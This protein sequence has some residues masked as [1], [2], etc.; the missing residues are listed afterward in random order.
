MYFSRNTPH[1]QKDEIMQ[2]LG[3]KEEVDHF[4]SYLG[5]PTLVGCSKYHSFFYL[6]DRVLER[7]AAIQGWERGFY[8][9]SGTIHSHLHN[10]YV[11][12]SSEIM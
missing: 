11:P 9:G 1:N 5:L 3:V 7:Y 12:T 4:E 2:T 10:G 8:Q 6:K